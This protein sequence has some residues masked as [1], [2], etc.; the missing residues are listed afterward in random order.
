[1]VQTPPEASRSTNVLPVRLLVAGSSPFLSDKGKQN[2]KSG[3][4]GIAELAENK[5]LPETKHKQAAP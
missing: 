2:S 1:M 4:G 3:F 5:L